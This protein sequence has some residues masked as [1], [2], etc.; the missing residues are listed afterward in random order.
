MRL[1]RIASTRGFTLIELMVVV[2]IVGILAGIAYPSYVKHV[3][4]GRRAEAQSVMNEVGQY[5]QRYYAANN[6]YG[7]VTAAVL[8]AAGLS[9]SPKS[10]NT[11]YYG[12][13]VV[14]TGSSPQNYSIQA[15]PSGPQAGD[16]CGILTLSDTGAKG[17]DAGAT[18]NQCWQ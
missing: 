5:M 16:V 15:T 10:G 2:A 4:H 1:K 17:Q 18:F 8:S 9:Q 11:A 7:G 13:Q 12:I 3:Q 6:N 14:T